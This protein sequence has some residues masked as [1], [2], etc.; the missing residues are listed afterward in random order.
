MGTS[1]NKSTR[2]YSKRHL[3]KELSQRK[4]R[5]FVNKQ[6]QAREAKLQ[7]AVHNYQ[8]KTTEDEALKEQENSVKTE[9]ENFLARRDQSDQE[10][11]L[12]ELESSEL[13]SNLVDELNLPVVEKSAMQSSSDDEAETAD[14][15]QI[16]QEIAQYKAQLENLKERDPE[17]YQYLQQADQQLLNFEDK[18][19]NTT[20]SSTVPEPTDKAVR[21]LTLD[22]VKRWCKGVKTGE[23]PESLRYLIT[24]YSVACQHGK[25][26]DEPSPFEFSSSSVYTHLMTFILK[27]GEKTFKTHLGLDKKKTVR[28]V[29]LQEA[30]KLHKD[31]AA[32]LFRFLMSTSQLLEQAN[33]DRILSFVLRQLRQF[34]SFLEIIPIKIQKLLLRSS[35]QIFSNGKPAPRLQ[36]VLLIRELVCHGS[37]KMKN[38]ALKG[39]YKA[40][41]VAAG[42]VSKDSIGAI[43]FMGTCVIE[44]YRLAPQSAYQSAFKFLKDLAMELREAI[45]LKEKDSWKKVLNWRFVNCL[46]LWSRL[47]GSLMDTEDLQQLLYPIAQLLTGTARFQEQAKFLP[48]RLRLLSAVNRLSENTR[49]FIPV[50]SLLL[51]ILSWTELQKKPKISSNKKCPNISLLLQV[52]DAILKSA[53][54]QAEVMEQT[55]ELLAQHLGQFSH[56]ISFPEMS[57]WV[58]FQLKKISK[59][60]Q[61]PSYKSGIMQLVTAIKES[62]EQ[63]L[64]RRKHVT[65][66]PRDREK[67]LQF[68]NESKSKGKSRLELLVQKLEQKRKQRNS[69]YSNEEEKEEGEEVITLQESAPEPQTPLSKKQKKK[70]TLNLSDAESLTS[71]E[72][73]IDELL[74]ETQHTIAE[75]PEGDDILEDYVPSEDEIED[76]KTPTT[77]RK[78]K[79]NGVK[80]RWQKK[81]RARASK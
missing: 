18:N 27:E 34:I 78:R 3:G 61:F 37:E 76:I 35:L 20:Q 43:Y 15:E 64:S 66:S 45:I 39:I 4:K 17:F 22:Q 19:E 32:Q 36:A 59:S 30:I 81:S 71:N 53:V 21:Q 25:N 54:F 9:K 10:S 79:G 46:E 80:Q 13:D 47:I 52:D 51:G 73:S 62:S 1:S 44:I 8:A 67:V 7:K 16:N 55:L 41:S 63:V 50:A 58:T 65:F 56:S 75:V 72:E 2:K 49:V 31:I 68:E 5:R 6:K 14:L 24:A 57:H 60:V 70:D 12:E 26:P 29:D 11:D 77:K 38:L 33:D 23:S 69:M 48:M 28:T 42:E 40:F 74:Q